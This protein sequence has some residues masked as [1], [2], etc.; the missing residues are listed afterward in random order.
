MQIYRVTICVFLYK[1]DADTIGKGR[2]RAAPRGRGRGS[3]TSKR[4]RKS[5][6]TSSSSLGRLLASRDDDDEDDDNMAKKLN[7]SQ[8]RVTD[9]IL[10]KALAF[11]ILI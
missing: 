2:K 6:N 9:A 5:D 11:F 4:G 10:N 1:D 3:T 8:P 7:K